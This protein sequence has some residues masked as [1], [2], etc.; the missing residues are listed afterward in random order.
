VGPSWL[1]VSSGMDTVRQHSTHG[2]KVLYQFVALLLFLSFASTPAECATTSLPK[3][4][5]LAN[6]VTY[7]AKTA[8]FTQV[9]AVHHPSQQ[10]RLRDADCLQQMYECMQV[11]AQASTQYV[12][13]T[14]SFVGIRSMKNAAADYGYRL[15][16]TANATELNY[17]FF[18]AS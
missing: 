7:F 5:H 6:D 1:P 2:A 18:L 13:L 9:T 10:L 17:P 8:N 12:A 15:V 4:W 11:S 16:N 14:L 3:L